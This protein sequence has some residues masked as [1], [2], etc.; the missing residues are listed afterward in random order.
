MDPRVLLILLAS[1]LITHSLSVE[2]AHHSKP[3]RSTSKI[4][5]MGI[6]YCDI[7][8]NNTFSK[9]SYFLPGV[10]V[11]MNCKFKA[12]SPTTTEQI[13]FS[14][15]RTTDKYGVYKLDIPSVD[16]VRCAEGLSMESFCQASLIGSSSSSCS[17]PGLKTTTDGITF[18]SKH[19]N[20]CIYS[21]N[22]LNYRPPKRN[23]TL[24]GEYKEELSN[25]LN[26]SKFFYPFFPPFGFPF[27]F[28]SFPPM[29]SLPFPLPPFPSFPFPPLPPFTSFPFPPL[30]FS[31]P[32]SLPFPFPPLPPLP[33]TPSLFSPS[34]PPPAF[35]LMDP[36]TWI[37]FFPP[38]PPRQSQ[39]QHP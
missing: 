20:L 32:P 3:T 33:P 35:N 16:G 15:N 38:S 26:S 23:I 6:V 9:Q 7:C 29:P 27:P 8:S 37:P 10:K 2:A 21:L 36:R 31:K 18:K 34:P 22:A 24:C 25:S 14:V 39:N 5:V 12:T 19:A 4:S 13:S 11:H 1:L 17:I 30:P 28:P